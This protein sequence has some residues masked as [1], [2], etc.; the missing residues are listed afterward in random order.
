VELT[1]SPQGTLAPGDWAPDGKSL[2]FFSTMNQ[3]R[4]QLY[5][6]AVDTGKITR[7]TDD[8]ADDIFPTWSRT[9]EWI[10]FTSHRGGGLQL[11]KMPSS[12]GPA[13]V[14]VPRGVGSAQE[15]ADG[16]WLWFADWPDG[17]LYRMPIGGGEIVRV[18]DRIDNGSGYAAT[19]GGV[20]YWGG[21]GS[22][23]G[24]RYFDLQT[25]R[26]ELVF[27]PPLPALPNL[28]I[29]P[30]GRWLCFPLIE[31]NSQELLM[32]ENWR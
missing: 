27:Q 5:R 17:G 7:L 19:D 13:K 12:G 24:L 28:T 8:A 14:L 21:S 22:Q 16:R 9:G 29:S 20:Y 4:W 30:D 11:Y 2:A 25:R 32:I 15:S 18:I 3:G 6:V 10:Y 31:R 26:D 1:S 23:A